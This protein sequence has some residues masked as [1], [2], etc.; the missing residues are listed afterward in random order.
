MQNVLILE[1]SDTFIPAHKDALLDCLNIAEKGVTCRV[2]PDD[3]LS[4]DDSPIE[5]APSTLDGFRQQVFEFL[6]RRAAL[7]KSTE[8]FVWFTFRQDEQGDIFVSWPVSGYQHLPSHIIARD[9]RVIEAGSRLKQR[10]HIKAIT[11]VG[12]IRNYEQYYPW[13]KEQYEV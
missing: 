7:L 2:I 3:Q 8:Q 1:D 11:V 10:R 12:P 6:Q 5:I 4:V 9:E 13:I